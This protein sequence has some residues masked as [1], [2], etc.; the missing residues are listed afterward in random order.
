MCGSQ[1]EVLAPSTLINTLEIFQHMTLEHLRFSFSLLLGFVGTLM[2]GI[3]DGSLCALVMLPS[4][5]IGA[6]WGA[7]EGCWEVGSSEQSRQADYS[8]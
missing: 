7:I 8:G 1:C 3:I 6:A 2:F 5:R 4:R